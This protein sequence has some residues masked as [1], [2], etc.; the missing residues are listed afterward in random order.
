MQITGAGMLQ[1]LAVGLGGFFGAIARYSISGLVQRRFPGFTPAGT[2][3][4]NVV[5]CLLIG[6]FMELLIERKLGVQK[7]LLR[8]LM[9]T[10]F[11]GSLT[12]FSTFGYETVELIR[13]DEFRPAFFNMLGNVV[14]GFSAVWIGR[15]L[16]LAAARG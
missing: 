1:L 15:W 13:E 12:T 3:V 5:G 9:V 11:L 10:G 14:L 6:V 16:V 2:L 4:V 7:E 8:S